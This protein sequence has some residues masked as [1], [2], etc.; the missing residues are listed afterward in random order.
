MLDAPKTQATQAPLLRISGFTQQVFSAVLFTG[1]TMLTLSTSAAQTPAA[2]DGTPNLRE[3]KS[4]NAAPV[5]IV[6]LDQSIRGAAL[7]VSG[8]M[9]ALNG[10]AFITGNGSITAGPKT[11]EVTLPYRGTLRVCT[12]TTINI[13]ADTSQPTGGALPGLLMAIDHGAVE[14]SFANTPRDANADTLMTPDFR[15]IINGSG[16]SEVKVRLGTAGDTCIDNS[17]VAGPYVVVTSLFDSGAYRVQPGQRVMLQHGSLQ[18]VVDQEKEPCGCP[19]P[20]PTEA[21]NG[22]EFP[23][24]QSEGLAPTPPPAPTPRQ[25]EGDTAQVVPPLVYSSG[26]VQEPQPVTSSEPKPAPA[27]SAPAP[28]QTAP[29]ENKKKPGVFTKIGH[30]FRRVFG[31]E[32]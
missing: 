21:A 32:D 26:K 20:P 31:A 16:A 9:Q 19:P 14:M 1:I 5:A 22:N 10:R 6:P 17:G 18:E 23:L 28:S 27:A 24:A 15:I 30:F 11:A 8:S 29:A 3:G 12:S 4:L 2:A 25:T 7:S 13:A